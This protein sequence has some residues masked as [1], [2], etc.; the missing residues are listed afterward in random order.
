MQLT[1]VSL[2][3]SGCIW[4]K[5]DEKN[6]CD[7][8]KDTKAT[9]ALR[10]A[11][12]SDG[13]YDITTADKASST[14]SSFQ[15]IVTW[16]NQEH[17]IKGLDYIFF[18]GDVNNFSLANY[19]EIKSSYFY[20]LKTPY[21][22]IKGNH[23]YVNPADPSYWET[24]WGAGLNC[25][26]TSG[27]TTFILAN[28]TSY[29]TDVY[30]FGC[31]YIDNTWLNAALAG[32][33]TS[34]NVFIIMHVSPVKVSEYDPTNTLSMNCPDTLAV[35]NSYTNIK[36]IINGHLHDFTDVK[37]I[38]GKYFAWDGAFGNDHYLPLVKGYRIVQVYSDNSIYSYFTAGFDG[39]ISGEY[40]IKGK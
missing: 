10:F 9:V 32:S 7:F 4:N 16:L 35:I 25:T 36:G 26:F 31:S 18:N 27:N 34:K 24:T 15:N 30:G 22:V 1:V 14:R 6:E 21:Y 13:H 29:N 19:A 20:L 12:A 33:L 5:D 37:K 40:C 3:S 11:V 8:I 39:D 28:T 23:D 2:I 17:D 38:S